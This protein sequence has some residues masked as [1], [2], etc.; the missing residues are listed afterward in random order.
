M[1]FKIKKECVL[2]SPAAV[3]YG[4]NNKTQYTVVLEKRLKLGIK[5]E[6]Q[7][8]LTLFSLF[9]KHLFIPCY[10]LIKQ[11]GICLLDLMNS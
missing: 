9:K 4:E 2:Y 6:H 11:T 10:I 1:K 8:H 7:N 3:K 5:K